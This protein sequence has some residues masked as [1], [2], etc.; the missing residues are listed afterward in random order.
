[1]LFPFLTLFNKPNFMYG[2]SLIRT[3]STSLGN[4]SDAFQ[5]HF[6]QPLNHRYRLLKLL[7]Q[8]GFGRT[9]LAVPDHSNCLGAFPKLPQENPSAQIVY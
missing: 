6:N 4:G 9:L 1:M 7:G 2:H 3:P 5:D 8:G